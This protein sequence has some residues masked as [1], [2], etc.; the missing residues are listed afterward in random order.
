MR[1]STFVLAVEGRVFDDWSLDDGTHK[2]VHSLLRSACCLSSYELEGDEG[3]F[4]YLLFA[5]KRELAE[6]V[7]YASACLEEDDKDTEAAYMDLFNQLQQTDSVQ[8]SQWQRDYL[9]RV[10]Q[11]RDA[12]AK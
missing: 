7:H 8:L 10:R 1:E 5:M 12:K 4:V 11:E 9:R 3:P 2:V 6:R